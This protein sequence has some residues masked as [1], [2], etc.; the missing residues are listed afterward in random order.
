MMQTSETNV[1]YDNDDIMILNG[2]VLYSI[3]AYGQL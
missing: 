3:L 2:T 1:E